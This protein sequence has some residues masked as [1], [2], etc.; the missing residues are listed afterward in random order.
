MLTKIVYSMVKLCQKN[1][2]YKKDEVSCLFNAKAIL[3][4]ILYFNYLAILILIYR[5]EKALKL[6]FFATGQNFFLVLIYPATFFILLS[7]I[8]TKKRINQYN[9]SEKKQKKYY[10]S[11]LIYVLVSI[12]FLASAA[13]LIG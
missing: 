5:K 10:R 6:A 7:L 3:S 2:Q 8:F 4:L 9:F 12:I 13:L 1:W 11:Y